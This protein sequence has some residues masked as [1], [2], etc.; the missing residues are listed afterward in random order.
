MLAVNEALDKLAAQ[1]K[2]KAELVKLSYFAGLTI[3]EAAQVLRISEPTANRYWTFAKAW[4]HREIETAGRPLARLCISSKCK[5]FIDVPV[6]REKSDMAKHDL[7][8]EKLINGGGAAPK[9][10]DTVTVH[11]VGTFTDG[12]KFDSSVDRKEPFKFVLGA[13][14][15]IAGWDLGVATMKIG[16]RVKMTVPP[17]L[18]YGRRRLSRRDSAEFHIDFRGCVAGCRLIPS[19]QSTDTFV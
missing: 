17:E 7:K 19:R 1:N 6:Y 4:L 16:D 9:K 13:G 11:Y 12:K 14:Q 8:I 3:E 5:G 15:V 10:G 2:L 18:A